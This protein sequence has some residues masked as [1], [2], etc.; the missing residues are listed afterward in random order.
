MEEMAKSRGSIGTFLWI[1][2]IRKPEKKRKLRNARR[3]SGETMRFG[4]TQT[5]FLRLRPR[6]TSWIRLSFLKSRKR[7]D[8]IRK[9]LNR[10]WPPENTRNGLKKTTRTRL[11]QEETEL[12][13]QC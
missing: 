7:S 8:W 10:A 1:Q 9:N 11:H 6:T 2:Y 5:A 4:S 12:P 3:S 13:T